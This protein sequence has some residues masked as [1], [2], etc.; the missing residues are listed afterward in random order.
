MKEI[1]CSNSWGGYISCIDQQEKR[2]GG[3]EDEEDG[4]WKSRRKCSQVLFYI[5]IN[6]IF[7]LLLYDYYDIYMGV[8]VSVRCACVY[9]RVCIAYNTI[10]RVFL[11][12]F[13]YLLS[14]LVIFFFFFLRFSLPPYT[15]LYVSVHQLRPSA[16]LIYSLIYSGLNKKES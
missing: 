7:L 12:S 10:L 2:N 4:G 1:T 6:A 14:F 5:N 3:G 8:C 13:L 11:S 15:P 16:C 9:L